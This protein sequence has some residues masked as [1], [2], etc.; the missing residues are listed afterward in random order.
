MHTHLHMHVHEHICR[1]VTIQVHSLVHAYVHLHT[2]ARYS[3]FYQSPTPMLALASIAL[4][5]LA[6]SPMIPHIC[7]MGELRD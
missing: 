5:C 2:T 3:L 4:H 1:H 6:V 7:I